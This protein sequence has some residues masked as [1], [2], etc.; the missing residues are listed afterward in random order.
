MR[1][2]ISLSNQGRGVRQTRHGPAGPFAEAQ[3]LLGVS[4][5]LSGVVRSCQELLGVYHYLS[6]QD[7]SGVYQECVRK[8]PG[9]LM[10]WQEF[11]SGPGNVAWSVSVVN[12]D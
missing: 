2:H 4:Q 6:C 3:E 8:L 12:R 10:I 1:C 9:I 7:L 5:E 11:G